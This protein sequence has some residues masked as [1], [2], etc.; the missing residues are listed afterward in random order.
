M[1]AGTLRHKI[2]IQSIS[3]TRD[4]RGETTKTWVTEKKLS[5]GIYPKNGTETQALHIENNA[6]THEIIT[7]FVPN[8]TAKMRIKFKDRIFDIESIIN[9]AERNKTL[10]FMCIERL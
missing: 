1:R 3:I 5:A 10:K 2:E 6:V 9:I 7:R 8:I 4:A